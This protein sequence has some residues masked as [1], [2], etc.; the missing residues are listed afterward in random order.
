VAF[1]LSVSYALFG[2]QASG[3]GFVSSAQLNWIG[4]VFDCL[5]LLSKFGSCWKVRAHGSFLNILKSDIPP[6]A[7]P[8]IELSLWSTVSFDGYKKFGIP[9]ETRAFNIR[10]KDAFTLLHLTEIGENGQTTF[11]SS[12]ANC[13]G[14]MESSLES[15]VQSMVSRY[16]RYIE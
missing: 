1:F 9:T 15:R 11:R 6:S 2:R 7:P 4:W 16:H 8:P 10:F 5:C 13:P 14:G 12:T 3:L